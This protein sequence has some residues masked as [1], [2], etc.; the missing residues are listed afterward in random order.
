PDWCIHVDGRTPGLARN[1]LVLDLTNPEVVE[2]VYGM[3]KKILS[4]A[5]IRYVT[6]DMNRPLT[7]LGSNYQPP[8]RQ[9]EISHRYVLAVYEM[10]ERLTTDFPHILVEGCSGGGARFDPGILYYCPQI[11]C[12]DDTD[13][14]ER[15]VIQ[16]GTAMV[17][18]LSTIGAHVSDCPNHVLGRTT[19]FE[20]RGYVA[21][22]GRA[23]V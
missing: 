22:I 12:S 23:H 4:E 10:L 3:L 9:G 8:E 19:P 21:Q 16:R 1:Q 14:I 15:L 5:N 6:W 20:T 2:T 11:W 18:P 17:Y 7:D 13:A